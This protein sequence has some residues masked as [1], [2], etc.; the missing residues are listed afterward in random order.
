MWYTRDSR[1]ACDYLA[2][3][4][5]TVPHFILYHLFRPLT[6]QD[7]YFWSY[8]YNMLVPECSLFRCTCTD[9]LLFDFHDL[10]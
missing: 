9:T 2:F 3:I 8:D 6:F 10:Y 1:G 7:M 4:S 5:Y